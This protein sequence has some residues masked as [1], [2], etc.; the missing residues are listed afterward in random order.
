MRP[1]QKVARTIEPVPKLSRADRAYLEEIYRDTWNYLAHFV[2][3]PTGLPYDSCAMQPPTS[4]TNVG[5]YLASVRTAYRTGLIAEEEAKRRVVRCLESLEEVEKWRGMPRP[6]ILTRTLAATF[7]EEF[8][9]APHLASLLAGLA[10]TKSALP[11]FS[12]RIHGM[13]GEMELK[14]LY[15]PRT[16]W[17]KGG[18]DVKT[19]NFAI[20]QPWGYWYYKFFASPVRLLSFYMIAKRAAPKKLWL[21]LVR[22]E[23][24]KE[25]ETFFVSGYEDA[26]LAEP[27][28]PAVFLDE[29]GT[30]MENSLRGMVRYQIKH[31]QRIDAPVWGWSS[32]ESPQGRY[33][34]F[35]LLRDDIVAPYAS[36]L[37]AVFYPKEAVRNLKKLEELGARPAG[38]D[39]AKGEN[40]GFRDS[41]NWKT[42][43][44]S[45]N[46]LAANQ[47]LGF[48]SLANLLHD[49]IVW[50]SFH[51]D[52]VAEKGFEILAEVFEGS[53]K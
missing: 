33:L 8:H 43:D 51:E 24:T 4:M 23:Q 39:R 49:G 32:A 1:A 50:K 41:F 22:P 30:E 42:G 17:L 46:Y 12:T 35:G 38:H 36:M 44:V 7:G 10:V 52:P 13:I 20:Y 31:A 9:Y 18:Y 3:E 45:R 47:A 28:I 16:G 15:D 11:E 40:F 5:L 27:F 6:W 21:S 53:R 2:Y 26:G 48:L 14:T 25:G 19:R 29:R 37:A 34:T